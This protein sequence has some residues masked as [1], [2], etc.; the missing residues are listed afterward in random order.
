L[1]AEVTQ[2]GRFHATTDYAD[3]ADADVITIS[4]ETPVGEDD[5]PGFEALKAA[6]MSVGKAMKPGTLVIIESTIAP[7]TTHAIVQPQLEAATSRS[8]NSGFFLGHC[9][10]RVM[11]GRLLVNLETMPRV[12]GGSTPET[13]EVM[14]E[15]YRTIVG[16]DADLDQTDCLTAELVKTS[17]NAFRDVNIAFANEMAL[18][19]EMVGGDAGKVR[20]LVNKVP[21]RDM[22]EPGAGV[23]GHCIP[24]D[25]WLLAHAAGEDRSRLRMLPAARA[26]N[27]F[28]PL[29]MVDLLEDALAEVGLG[30]AGARILVM[31]Y[32]YLADSDD[33]RNSPSV[34]TVGR[35]QEMGAE[36]R[37]HDPFVVGYQQDFRDLAQGVDAVVVM[38]KHSQYLKF[39][40]G[41]LKA[42][43]RT[44]VLVDGRDVFDA[45]EVEALGFVYRRVGLGRMAD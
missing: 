19:C 16:V 33:T 39:D 18:L 8:L 36:V 40:L 38:V 17:E 5:K 24:K 10:E 30:I 34:A 13:A 41:R 2:G 12:C 7:G 43:M 44:P 32:A 1:I 23:G 4:V 25:P 22:H 31:G 21:G 14:T 6:S 26:T 29:H 11:P 45:G 9:P 42:T 27:D 3:L 35:L 20:K 37:I 28:M 15:L